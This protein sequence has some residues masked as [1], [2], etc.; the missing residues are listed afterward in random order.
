[1][2]LSM[3]S[4]LT[5]SGGTWLYN[6]NLLYKI[7][8]Q[9]EDIPYFNKLTDE[10]VK[11]SFSNTLMIGDFEPQSPRPETSRDILSSKSLRFVLD[12]SYSFHH[13]ADNRIFQGLQILGQSWTYGLHCGAVERKRRVGR[14]DLSL[15][16]AFLLVNYLHL[17]FI[18]VFSSMFL[19]SLPQKFREM[20]QFDLFF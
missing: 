18:L 1:M 5:Y 11:E 20:I 3:I 15:Q 9:L 6:F 16:D 2:S 10:W 4:L 19:E 13:P 12:T 7:W 8:S 17:Y 14:Y